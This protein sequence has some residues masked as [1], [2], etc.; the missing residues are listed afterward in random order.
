MII[1]FQDLGLLFSAGMNETKIGPKIKFYPN[2]LNDKLF[3]QTE[4]EVKIKIINILGKII[5][6][7]KVSGLKEVDF[8]SQTKG[9]YLM[10]VSSDK[11]TTT[12]KLI[13]E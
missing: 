5:Y 6:E 8:S 1:S 10:N 9:L 2:P 12:L 4:E 3:I 13:K 11:R 7:E